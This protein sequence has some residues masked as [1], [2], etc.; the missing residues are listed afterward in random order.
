MSDEFF[1]KASNLI[2]PNAPIHKPNTYV[3]TGAWYDGWET[4][5]HNPQPYDHVILRIGPA[6]G[7]VR[8][9]EVDTA[10][11][12]GNQAPAVSVEGAYEPADGP[13]A[14]RKVTSADYP[15]WFSLLGVRAC[16]PSARHAWRVPTTAPQGKA[17]SPPVVTHVR[18][19]MYPDGGIA[20][21]RLYGSAVPA[22]PA[23]TATAAGSGAAAAPLVELSSALNG[24]LVVAFSDQHFGA[25]ANVLLPGRGLDMGDGWETKR[26]RAP[27]H[28]DWLVVRL[29]ARGAVARVVVD[30]LHFRGN[31]PRAVRVEACDVGEDAFADATGEKESGEAGVVEEV[32]KAIG[33]LG[34]KHAPW[35]KADWTQ[36]VPD[37]GMK[38]DEEAVVEGQGLTNCEGRVFSHVRLLIIP[39]GGVKRLRVFGTRL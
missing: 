23:A 39:D 6:A 18:L 10:F 7:R 13:D 33:N 15:G 4:R 24:G 1:A 31:F 29:A 21:F 11:F 32:G 20:R 14:D 3:A 12:D 16:G 25:A 26:S 8:G 17:Q 36:I 9:V 34:R 38:A 35:E 19:R 27:G 37:R 5:R 30:T 2:A 22:W 28:L